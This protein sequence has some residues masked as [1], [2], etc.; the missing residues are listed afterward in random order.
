LKWLTAALIT[1]RERCAVG[2]SP[3]RERLAEQTASFVGVIT[4]F[5]PYIGYYAAADLA[6]Q[7]LASHTNIADLIV[8]RGLMARE[9]VQI[10]MQPARLSG[11]DSSQPKLST[12]YRRDT[13]QRE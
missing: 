13:S 6:K 11:E 8:G 12:E 2:I 1:L 7:A 4:A 9:D 3:N 5:T 10:L